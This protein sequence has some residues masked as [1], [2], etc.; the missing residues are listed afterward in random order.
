M[1]QEFESDLD[2][3]RHPSLNLSGS[4]PGM[5]KCW[6]CQIEKTLDLPGTADQSIT[7]SQEGSACGVFQTY[8]D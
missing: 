8:D 6:V 7:W 3:H 1:N 5:G 4:S 2:L